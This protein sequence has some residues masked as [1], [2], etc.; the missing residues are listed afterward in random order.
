MNAFIILGDGSIGHNEVFQL[1][2]HGTLPLYR[3]TGG[4]DP[5]YLVLGTYS[6]LLANKNAPLRKL[7]VFQIKN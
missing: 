1:F 5:D 3:D 2:W 7:D 6:L 4:V